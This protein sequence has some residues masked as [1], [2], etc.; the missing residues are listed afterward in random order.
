M[1]QKQ[2]L[3]HFTVSD[4]LVTQISPK[5]Q[6]ENPEI[7][8]LSLSK[9]FTK[10]Q[11]LSRLDQDA[12]IT[13]IVT[14]DIIPGRHV[15]VK[16]LSYGDFNHPYLKT[17]WYT[18]DAD[19]TL[20]NLEA[21]LFAG[22]KPNSEGMTFCGDP[23]HVQGLKYAGIDVVSLANN[24]SLNFGQEGLLKTEALL[25]KNEMAYTG[26]GEVAEKTV[27]GIKFT[28][29]A[30]NGVEAKFDLGQMKKDITVAKKKSDLVV[31]M[32]HWGREYVRKPASSGNVAP[33]NPI[34]VAH[35][36]VDA[37]ADLVVGN[38][39]HWYQGVEI[40]KNK[41]IAYAHG[42]FVFDQMWSLETEQGVVGKYTFYKGKLVDAVYKPIQVADY[43][44]PYFLGEKAA[45]VILKTMKKYSWED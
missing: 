40:Y 5:K 41:L 12:L 21:P 33:D 31:V 8:K 17:A 43:N 44:Q 4:Q 9:V 23:R 32:P 26:N 2:F 14:G 22:C 38:H 19:L 34:T 1:A 3:N 7:Y 27:K 18:K 42:N 37:G 16:V 10:H 39:P 30:Y 25:K 13:I 15:N 36:I 11:D 6:T 45:N 20:S 28:F 35:A 29:L 24:H